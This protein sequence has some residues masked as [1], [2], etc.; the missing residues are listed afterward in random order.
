MNRDESKGTM[1]QLKGD[2]K[3]G[4]GKL[5]NNESMEAEGK[6]DRAKG[7]VQ[8]KFGEAKEKAAETFN[9]VTNK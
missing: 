6:V 8:E 4:F 1:N 3:E 2:V 5:T 9:D 7:T